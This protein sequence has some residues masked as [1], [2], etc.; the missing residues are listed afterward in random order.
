MKSPFR[1]DMS[2]QASMKCYCKNGSHKLLR[3]GMG[4]L[5]E[6][7][8]LERG[9]L[10]RITILSEYVYAHMPCPIFYPS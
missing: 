7:S 10:A 4:E 6:M 3:F 5:F 9:S 1:G 2:E 8:C